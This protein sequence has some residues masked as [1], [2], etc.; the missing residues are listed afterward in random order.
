MHRTFCTCSRCFMSEV[1][2]G[3]MLKLLYCLYMD[4]EINL[5]SEKLEVELRQPT[6]RKAWESLA[7]TRSFSSLQECRTVERETRRQQVE[8][9]EISLAGATTLFNMLNDQLLSMHE[10]VTTACREA[11]QAKESQACFE[12]EV[13]NMFQFLVHAEETM[14]VPASGSRTQV[15]T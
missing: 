14:Q 11:V 12:Q 13:D 6:K 5:V 8:A 1:Q 10:K 7:R 2:M 4:N 3:K 15:E 9:L